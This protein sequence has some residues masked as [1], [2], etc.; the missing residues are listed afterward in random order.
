MLAEL[1]IR[2]YGR[3]K[4]SGGGINDYPLGDITHFCRQDI[5]CLGLITQVGVIGG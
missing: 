5:Y 2:F 4:I 3:L 1:S